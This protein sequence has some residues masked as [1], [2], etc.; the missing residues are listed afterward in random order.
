MTKII[1]A[2]KKL[3]IGLFTSSDNKSPSCEPVSHQINSFSISASVDPE[4]LASEEF[5]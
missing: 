5:S 2:Y 3:N 1:V 4:Q